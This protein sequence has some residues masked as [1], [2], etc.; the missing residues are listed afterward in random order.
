[1]SNASPII[2][3]AG[4]GPSLLLRVVWFVFIGWW[5]G[6]IASGLAWLMLI[7]V[8]LLPI[9]LMIINRLPSIVTLRPQG[10]QWRMQDG[11]LV[12]G[13]RQR[14]FLLRAVYFLVIG[15]WACAFW[16]VLAYVA[17]LSLLGIPLAFWMYGRAGAVTTLYRS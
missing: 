8:I 6:A 15:W 10:Q 4:G 12:Q 3:V 1:M 2:V 7:T 13:Q 11:M 17:V 14:P 9:G 16:L 5:L